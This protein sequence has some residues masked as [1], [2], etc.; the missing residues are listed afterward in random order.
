MLNNTMCSLPTVTFGSVK[1]VHECGNTERLLL[2]ANHCV[3]KASTTPGVMVTLAV[4]WLATPGSRSRRSS[5]H[6]V[7]VNRDQASS[8]PYR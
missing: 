3:A 2:T 4:L 5:V 8:H 6:A 1:F 7:R